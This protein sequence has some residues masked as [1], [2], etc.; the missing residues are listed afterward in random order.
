MGFPELSA[1][2]AGGREAA[3][4][5]DKGE[6]SAEG[7]GNK[8]AGS[9]GTGAESDGLV[10]GLGGPT[11]QGFKEG[12]EFGGVPLEIERLDLVD[13]SLSGVVGNGRGDLTIEVGER[14]VL[15]VGGASAIALA[16]EWDGRGGEVRD[17]ILPPTTGDVVG[18]GGD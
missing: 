11:G 1:Q 16:D 13:P 18:R 8:F 15:R 9:E 4:V 17:E 5:R 2:A 3:V 6:L 7:L 12:P 14:G 10:G